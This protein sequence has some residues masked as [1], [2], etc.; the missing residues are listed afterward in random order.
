MENVIEKLVSASDDPHKVI[1]C[2][3]V[4]REGCFKNVEPYNTFITKIKNIIADSNISRLWELIQ[5]SE[6]I[7]SFFLL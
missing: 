1:E 3:K 2:L 6:P 5:N 7:F 4:Y